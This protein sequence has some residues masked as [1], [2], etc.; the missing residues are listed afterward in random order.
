MP[1]KSQKPCA[2]HGCSLLTSGRYCPEHQKL[3]AQQYE[4]HQ[5]DP[6]TRKRYGE[7]WRRI[8]SAF[9][10][11]NPLCEICQQ[12]GRLTPAALVHHKVKLSDGGANDREN[13][14]ALC[15]ECHSRLHAGQG[16]YF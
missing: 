11:A 9:L 6:A 2:H 3:A 5:R 10:A 14:Q 15:S 1:Y 12:A 16:D 4:R 7:T 13:L 8:R